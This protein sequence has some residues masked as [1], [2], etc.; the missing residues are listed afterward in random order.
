LGEGIWEH[1]ATPRALAALDA[2]PDDFT[3]VA[4]LV[5]LC[6][7]CGYRPLAVATAT[8][9]EWDAFESRY[10]AGRERWL[11]QSPDDPNADDVRAEIDT[12]RNGWLHGYRGI[13]GFAYLTLL[14]QPR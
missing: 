8:L 6:L 12:H 3:T 2:R 7:D 11:A 13:L 4:G 9:D 14:A 1:P 5:D 10:C